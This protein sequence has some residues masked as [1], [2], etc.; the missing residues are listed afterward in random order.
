V[1]RGTARLLRAV[2]YR[3]QC[4]VRLNV[5]VVWP[6]GLLKARHEPL[7]SDDR[8]ERRWVQVSRILGGSMAVEE[9]FRDQKDIRRGWALRQ[10]EVQSPERLNRLILILAVAYILL[11]ALGVLLIRLRGP[12]YWSS[13]NKGT[14]CSAFTV[15]Q[16]MLLHVC[17][18]LNRCLRCLIQILLPSKKQKWG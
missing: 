10:T 18:S 5:A 7:V 6:S 8:P 13:T 9:F 4:P 2:Q 1:R 14:P 15:G 11:L 3:K 12:R 16:V 17:T